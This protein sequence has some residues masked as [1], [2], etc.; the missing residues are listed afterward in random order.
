MVEALRSAVDT[1][2]TLAGARLRSDL[3]Y[4]VS[5]VLF[6]L[7]QFLITALDFVAVLIVFTNVHTL[8]G[9][10]V[11]EVAFLYG[12]GNL[13]FALADL[14][15]SAIEAVQIHVREGSL[16]RFLLRPASPMVQVIA[17]E[18]SLRR[19]GKVLEGLTVLV[20]GCVAAPIHWTVARAAMLVV[21]LLSAAAIFGAVWVLATCLCFWWV[22]A[23]EAANAVTYGG[24]FLAEYPLAV[25]GGILR[26][27]L[28]FGVPIAFANYFPAVYVLGR[29]D[30]LGAPEWISFVSPL[31]AVAV[32]LVAAAAWRTG[33]RHYRSTGS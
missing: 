23:R 24:A 25:Y 17:D 4:R 30:R 5:F 19:I 20:I 33:L 11:G 26:R 6:T 12:L 16:D 22:D 21:S 15:V 29:T 1:Y 9:W 28:A 27:V 14:F 7:S 31:V 8:K 2:R 3:E 13:G 10:T 32:F 18:F